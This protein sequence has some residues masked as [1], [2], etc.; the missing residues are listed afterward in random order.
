[1][2]IDACIYVKTDDGLPP[3]LTGQL[4][5]ACQVKPAQDYGPDGATHEIEQIWRYYGDGYERGPWPEI[6]AVLLRLF[7]SRNVV[8]V[9]YYGDCH[10]TNEPFTVDRLE[11][12]N[13]HFVSVANR[14]YYER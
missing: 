9:W 10:Y 2:G 6:V 13:R 4:P 5:P 1:M 3:E 7:A 11:E 8:S 12:M 14:P